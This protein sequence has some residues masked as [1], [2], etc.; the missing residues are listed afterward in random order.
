MKQIQNVRRL[1]PQTF[2][3]ISFNMK[4][5]ISPTNV[6]FSELDEPLEY[7]YRTQNTGIV[8]ETLRD[9]LLLLNPRQDFTYIDELIR[10]L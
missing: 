3:L 10:V 4:N 7:L 1:N 8:D 6:K 5:F 2:K 9:K